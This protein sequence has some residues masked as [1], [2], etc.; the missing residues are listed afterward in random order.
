MQEFSKGISTVAGSAL[1]TMTVDQHKNKLKQYKNTF[2][3]TGLYE[4]VLV[5]V[6][7]ENFRCTA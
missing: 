6:H 4:L 5:A 7:I 1:A 2:G 3:P